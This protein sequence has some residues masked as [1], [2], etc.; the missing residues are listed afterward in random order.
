M[1][2]QQVNL[3]PKTDNAITKS[4]PSQPVWTLST[5]DYGFWDG[6]RHELLKLLACYQKNPIIHGS[7]DIN[8]K[9]VTAA[10]PTLM[11]IVN[12]GAKNLDSRGLKRLSQ[13][14]IKRLFKQWDEPNLHRKSLADDQELV[15]VTDHPLLD[16]LHSDEQDQNFHSLLRLITVNICIYGIAFMAKIRDTL[17]RV[18]SYRYLPAYNVSPERGADGRVVGWFYSSS[19]GDSFDLKEPIDKDD[20]IVIRWPSI[21]DPHAGGDSPLKSALRKIDLSGK[22]TDWQ[23]WLITNRARPDWLFVPKE[24]IG[25]EGAARAEK[26]I[27]DKFRG[28]G[29]G[30]VAIA[31]QAG[32]AQ[33]LNW[34]PTDLAPLKFDEELKQAILFALGIPESFFTSDSNKATATASLEQWARQSLAPIVALLEATLNG[35][36]KEYGDGLIWVFESV[37]PADREQE[38]AEETFELAKWTGAL[39]AGAITDDEYRERVLGLE[40]MPEADKP[41][42]PAPVI[43]QTINQDVEGKPEVGDESAAEDTADDQPAKALDLLQ[44]NTKVAKGVVDRATAINLVAYSLGVSQAEAKALVTHPKTKASKGRKALPKLKQISHKL[45][46]DQITRCMDR[47]KSHYMKQLTGNHPSKG[48]DG[49]ELVT[50]SMELPE[51]FT[52]DSEWDEEDAKLYKP[53]VHLQAQQTADSRVKSF[54]EIG[55]NEDDFSVVPQNVDEAVQKSTLKFAKSTNSTTEMNLNDALKQLRRDLAT[56]VKE[57]D[58]VPMMKSKVEAIFQDIESD[59]A[60]LIARTEI[61][62]AMHES[63][64]ITAKASGMVKGFKLLASSECCD[65]CADLDGKEIAV[66]GEKF[67]EDDDY[68]S[69]VLPA[70]P[71]CRCT[72]L[73]VLDMDALADE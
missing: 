30:R 25:T 27:N 64:R 45:L 38:L 62:R 32:S 36:A 17:G 9:G 58:P 3:M 47:Q 8:A 19:F 63:Q 35:L 67:N 50:K 52:R 44:L 22:W 34:S 73:E 68:D 13:R 65:I 26:A 39:S 21:S 40:P 33:P 5:P 12:S 51:G 20:M 69:S 56:G 31:D 61:S 70:H 6:D 71:N 37:I 29:N 28:Q 54:C 72:M 46:A 49:A 43:L 7:I 60:D 53:Y 15:E 42:A 16:A 23:D 14:R 41:A 11:K 66:D 1:T 24:G 18:T 55:A 57:G 48:L 10:R 2:N 4:L 59:R